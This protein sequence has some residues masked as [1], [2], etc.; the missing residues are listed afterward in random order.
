M[1]TNQSN[2]SIY[3]FI[4]RARTPFNEKFGIPR[5]ASLLEKIECQIE[6]HPPYHRREAFNGLE[7]VSHLWILS[8]FNLS[9]SS[10]LSVKPPR[11]G[12]NKKLGVFA[13]RSPSRPN[14]IGLSLVQLKGIEFK[15]KKTILTTSGIDLVD[16]TPIIDIKPYLNYSDSPNLASQ[17]WIDQ[18]EFIPFDSINYSTQFLA[19]IEEMNKEAAKRLIDLVEI[20]FSEDPRPAYQNQDDRVYKMRI[21]NCDLHWLVKN[22]NVEVLDIQFN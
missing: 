13:T 6:I 10:K 17:S 8:D 20:V 21:M 14:S 11:L 18:I 2:E 22:Q 16:Q 19:K 7:K 3:K 1:K 5:Q 12:G 4:G 9:K 15:N